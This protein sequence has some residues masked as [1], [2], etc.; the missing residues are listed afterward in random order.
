MS[1]Q[2]RTNDREW[3][4]LL[5]AQN[6]IAG[7]YSADVPGTANRFSSRKDF[8]RK[9]FDFRMNGRRLP[10]LLYISPE[11]SVFEDGNRAV[12]QTEMTPV[13]TAS[14]IHSF[15][16]MMQYESRN[17]VRITVGFFGYSGRSDLEKGIASFRKGTMPDAMRYFEKAIVSEG[18]NITYRRIAALA[19]AAAGMNG[20]AMEQLKA[21]ET[22][23]GDEENAGI[24]SA[25]VDNIASDKNGAVFIAADYFRNM[26]PDDFCA[27]MYA[28]LGNQ[29]NIRN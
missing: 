2:L 21:A 27:N 4:F 3:A 19:Y 26:Y 14:F 1:S 7:K 25:A 29:V 20:R 24:Y 16:T 9:Y 17:P 5:G 12:K 15:Y 10:V 6:K 22:L 8:I 13:Y 28:A 18:G 11:Q 23:A